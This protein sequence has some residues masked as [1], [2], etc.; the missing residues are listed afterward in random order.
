MTKITLAV[1]AS[2]LENLCERVDELKDEL[3][4]ASV[5]STEEH[6]VD[7]KNMIKMIDQNTEFRLK[8]KGIIGAATLLA[9][10]VGG[11]VIFI[12]GKVW[13]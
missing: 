9:G 12:A 11:L 8:A 7:T 4:R 2:K 1:L 13:K 6:R 3:Q 5:A 10:F